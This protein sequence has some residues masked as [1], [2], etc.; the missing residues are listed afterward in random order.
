M[1]VDSS[2]SVPLRYCKAESRDDFVRHCA[3]WTDGNADVGIWHE[4]GTEGRVL[5]GIDC[6][7]L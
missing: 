7:C 6:V 5:G 2:F 3:R 1:G 4:P